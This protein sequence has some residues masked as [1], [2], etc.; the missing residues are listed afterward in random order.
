MTAEDDRAEVWR[1]QQAARAQAQRDRLV[2]LQGNQAAREQLRT[3]W[4][5]AIQAALERDAD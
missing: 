3:S 5:P 2:E 4:Q 1:Q